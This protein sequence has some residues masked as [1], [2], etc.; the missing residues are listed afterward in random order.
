M[1]GT[2]FIRVI[3]TLAFTGMAWHA[4]AAEIL[5]SARQAYIT[6]FESGKVLFAKNAE[7]PMKPASMAKIMTVF[8]VFQRIADGSLRLENKFL[9]SEKAWRKGGSKTFVEVGSRVSV[10]DLLHGV[11]VQSGNDAA[12]VLAEGI[13]GTEDAF[14]E[15]MNFGEKIG[16]DTDQF[17]KCDRMARPRFADQCK[18]F[19]YFN[20]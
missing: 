14:A 4:T 1:F 2:I 17:S 12:I 16:Y 19:E 5:T 7:V 9:V 11:I 13:A 8:V 18:R 15:E 3:F 6:D 10:N 20:N